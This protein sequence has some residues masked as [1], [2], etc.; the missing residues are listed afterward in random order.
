MKD[1]REDIDSILPS[2]IE[3]RHEL[4][5]HPELGYQEHETAR[6]LLDRLEKLPGVVIRT[7]VAETGIVATLGTDKSGPC[8]ALRADMDALPI[9]E[10]T[11]RHYA[12]QN[13]GCMHACGHDGHMTC[14][15]GAAT[16]LAGRADE[17]KGPVKFIFQPAEEGGAGGKRMYQEGAL[18]DPPVDAIFAL[19]A[20]PTLE[21][22]TLAIRPGPI[23]AHVTDFEITVHGAG[24]H[25]AMPHRGID[26]ILV[27]SHVVVALQSIA[28]RNTDP[29]D[30]A[31]VTV[32][33]F[34]AGTATNII[35]PV[36]RLRGTIR[37]LTNK[38]K[39]ATKE[40]LRQIA[41]QTAAAYRGRA[42]VEFIPLYPGLS[43]DPAAAGFV[44]EVAY[45]V[46]GAQAVIADEPPTLGGED[47]AFYAR[48]IPAAFWW[49]GVRPKGAETYPGLHQPTFDFNDDVIALGVRLHCE[50]ALRFAASWGK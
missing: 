26:T 18:K 22:G 28:A 14:L 38:T 29:T 10:E 23:M 1:L 25:A 16:V 46:L 11:G 49:L 32:G 45:D 17:L 39:V 6:R 48:S 2:L 34:N 41:E 33:T 43:N 44:A 35:P 24:T 27:A 12:S 37:A 42:E 40:R 5:A 4:H 47:F 31:V 8:I 3:L 21:A 9:Q 30:S 20:W 7:G 50:M 15:I 19:H 36:A 13:A